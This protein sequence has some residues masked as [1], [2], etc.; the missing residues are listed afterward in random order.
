[1]FTVSPNSIVKPPEPP[2]NNHRPKA[3]KRSTKEADKGALR[4]A[5]SEPTPESTTNNTD[6]ATDSS[7]TE[8]VF[9]SPYWYKLEPFASHVR[10]IN[11]RV[12][13][14]SS[15]VTIDEA[16]M[17]FRGRTMHT[18]KLKNKPIKEGYKNW[19]CADHG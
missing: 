5:S 2:R 1:M 8:K 10:D 11:K 17:A 14:P 3:W 6:E 12:Y 18:T 15:H 7:T 16:M 9:S 4:E 13:T 19:L